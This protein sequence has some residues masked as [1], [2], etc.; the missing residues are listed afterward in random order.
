[1]RVNDGV[2]LLSYKRELN[3]FPPIGQFKGVTMQRAPRRGAGAD[4]EVQFQRLKDD[5]LVRLLA[6]ISDMFPHVELID[7]MQVL[8][9]L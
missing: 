8:Y 7:A 5:I 3:E 4:Q 2:N 1:M 9:A 6:N